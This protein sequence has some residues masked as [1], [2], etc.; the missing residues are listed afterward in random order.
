[1]RC[2]NK[3]SSST[4]PS[5]IVENAPLNFVRGGIYYLLSGD[6]GDKGMVG[7]YWST[8]VLNSTGAPH[9]SFRPSRFYPQDGNL[10]GYGFSVH[11]ITRTNPRS[12]T[13]PSVIVE[14]APL[15]FVRKIGRASC[16]ER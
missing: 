16:R 7:Y 8:M 9:L 14:N 10:R 13:S 1:M 11:C 5:V 12:S 15:N 2:K 4:S 6:T 3:P